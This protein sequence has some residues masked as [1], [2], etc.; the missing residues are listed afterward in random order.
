MLHTA[1]SELL[2]I[3]LPV[4]QAG[5]GPFTSAHLVA[6]VSNAGALG[7][8]G[9]GARSLDDFREQLTLTRSL[10]D[11]PFA[12][13]HTVP[14][15]NEEA[16][17]LTLKAKPAL[18]SFALGDPGDLVKEAHEAGILVMHQVTTVE[19]ARR[20]ADLGVD[21]IVAQGGEAGGFGGGI[22]TLA[23]VP[24][25][26]DTVGPVPVVA[27]GG[28]ADGRGLAAALALGAEG[29]NIGTRFLASAEAPISAGW[30]QA[31]LEAGSENALK[32]EV[33]NDI[34]PLGADDY[35]TSPRTLRSRFVDEWIDRREEA[36]RE[37]ERL[38][39]EIGGAVGAGRL[40]DL[41]PFAGQ[42][43]GL[44]GDILPAAE[45]VRCMVEEAKLALQRARQKVE[46]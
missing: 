8:L 18:V 17:A 1:L 32:A 3:E 11:R 29:V 46:G 45:I 12:V 6:A 36:E 4:I 16:F 39:A 26:V 27:S 13:N 42:S 31:I 9:A 10:T 35:A 34:F 44:V 30:K 40:G 28:I 22:S 25:V 7:S 15:L 5:M 33:W 2:G 38:R 21:V 43:A 23:L 14:R 37:G 20:A 24:Q 41:F 19:Q